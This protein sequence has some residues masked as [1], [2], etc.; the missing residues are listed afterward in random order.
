MTQCSRLKPSA[1]QSLQKRKRKNEQPQRSLAAPSTVPQSDNQHTSENGGP[2]RPRYSFSEDGDTDLTQSRGGRE[3]GWTDTRG[4]ELQIADPSPHLE[5]AAMTSA[6]VLD[7][8]SE[9]KRIRGARESTDDRHPGNEESTDDRHSGNE[10]LKIEPLNAV[11]EVEMERDNA[12]RSKQPRPKETN[13]SK[14][15]EEYLNRLNPAQNWTKYAE[16]LR[17]E[18]MDDNN[19]EYEFEEMFKPVESISDVKE[20]SNALGIPFLVLN[21]IWA[22]HK[23]ARKSKN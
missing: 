15:L 10:E 2:K 19:A 23:A 11:H 4:V 21:K 5:N 3:E 13:A 7:R 8:R 17:N 9:M 16:K 1:E 20:L 6:G 12:N 22:A 18:G 14:S